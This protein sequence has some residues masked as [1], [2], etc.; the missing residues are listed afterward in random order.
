MTLPTARPSHSSIRYAHKTYQRA[1]RA[2]RCSP[3]QIPLLVTL[4]SQSVSL[5]AITG[6]AGVQRSYT[7]RPL[8]ESSA[9]NALIWLIQV[10]LLR[11]EVDGQGITDSFRLTL[12]GRQLLAQWEAEGQPRS[13]SWLDYLLDFCAHW[14]GL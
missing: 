6:R 8:T 12:L 1:E 2:W 10:G 7:R 3:F 14:I 11:R 13:P 9:E 4:Q 5:G